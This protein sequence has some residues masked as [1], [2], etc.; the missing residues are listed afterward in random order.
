MPVNRQQLSRTLLLLIRGPASSETRIFFKEDGTMVCYDRLYNQGT[1]AILNDHEFTLTDRSGEI[2]T[3]RWEDG[4]AFRVDNPLMTMRRADDVEN[5]VAS[6]LI[7]SAPQVWARVKESAPQV[8][9]M[10]TLGAG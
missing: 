6:F 10:I 5:Q 4:I 3:W 9:A 8:W 1:Y 7:E 2:S